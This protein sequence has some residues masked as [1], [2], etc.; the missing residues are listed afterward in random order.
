MGLPDTTKLKQLEKKAAAS[1]RRIYEIFHITL[2]LFPP[3]LLD[4]PK[5]NQKYHKEHPEIDNDK[6]NKSKSGA[7][8]IDIEI[9]LK[10]SR[11]LNGLSQMITPIKRNEA[12]EMK[13]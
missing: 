13:S 9:N 10:N 5:R 3:D 6:D 8:Q 12:D 11:K 7:I 2:L 4:S 1:C